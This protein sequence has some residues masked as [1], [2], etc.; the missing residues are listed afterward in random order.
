MTAQDQALTVEERAALE[1]YAWALD[2]T[3]SSLLPP[4]SLADWDSSCGGTFDDWADYCASYDR[5]EAAAEHEDLLARLSAIRK[6]LAWSSE[7]G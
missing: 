5:G 3:T 1:R 4:P 6:T 7:A 2:L